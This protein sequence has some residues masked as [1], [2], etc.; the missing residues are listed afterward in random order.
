[1]VGSKVLI[2]ETDESFRRL[3]SDRLRLEGYRVHE[4]CRESEAHRMLMR[5]ELDVALLGF[6]GDKQPALGLLRAIKSVQPLVEV[7]LLRSSEDR[8]LAASIQGM[9]LGAFDELLIPFDM[10]TLVGR[11]QEACR[12]KGQRESAARQMT[13]GRGSHERGKRG[14]DGHDQSPA[15]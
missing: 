8:S 7:I 11:I 5:K 3:I 1:M 9:R 12:R 10:E 6:T 15:G 14:P 4:A 2:V 13:R